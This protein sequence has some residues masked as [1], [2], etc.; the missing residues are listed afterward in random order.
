MITVNGK[1][2]IQFDPSSLSSM[3]ALMLEYGTEE[4]VYRGQTST[5]V[6][7]L[8]SLHPDYIIVHTFQPNHWV[9]EDV[10]WDDGTTEECYPE[11]WFE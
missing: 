2:Q 6:T 11:K 7:T 9:R 8:I 1:Q 4:G 10:Y 5:G 3:R